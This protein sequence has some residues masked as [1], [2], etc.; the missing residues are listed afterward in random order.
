MYHMRRLGIILPLALLVS[1]AA[2]CRWDGGA[3]RERAG[4]TAF[5]DALGDTLRMA[6]PPQ[7]IVSLAPNVT[8]LVYL[9]GAQDRLVGVTNV[10]DWPPEAKKKP[11]VT[12]FNPLN[13]EAIMAAR[14][15]LVL[16]NRGNAAA[17][18]ATLRD[19]RAPLFALEMNTL[20]DLPVGIRTLGRLLGVSA[21][22]DS[23]A[24]SWRAR[25]A[26]VAAR[27]ADVPPQR[28]PVVFFGS[29]VE[30]IFSVGPGSFIYDLIERAG[31]R[32]AFPDAGSA[33]PRIDLETLVTRDPDVIIVTGQM[34]ADSAR[35]AASLKT[36][37]GWRSLRAVQ[38][39]RVIVPGDA[40]MREG[41]RLVDAL[42]FVARAL[43][44]DQFPQGVTARARPAG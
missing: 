33:W 8:E 43:Y 24:A 25:M 26:A 40:I 35:I 32:N 30:P 36:A 31:G 21:R 9:L 34:T 39:G 4:A 41:P 16:A 3:E 1:L 29:T 28:R 19:M 6:A 11:Q 38:G 42:E 5:V 23:V 13:I 44:P 2:G 10:C 18:L 17:D 14:P 22:G 12:S 27:T 37:P 20:A 15:D 7:R